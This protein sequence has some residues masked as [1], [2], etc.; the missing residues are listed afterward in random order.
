MDWLVYMNVTNNIKINIITYYNIEYK[1]KL[2][3]ILYNTLFT[4][5]VIIMTQTNDFINNLRQ[6][7]DYQAAYV[8]TGIESLGYT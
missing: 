1:N 3:F 7:V 2:I 5:E 4:Q 6:K 8:I